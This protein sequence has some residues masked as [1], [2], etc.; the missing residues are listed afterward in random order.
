MCFC[1]GAEQLL[2]LL[3][4]RFGSGGSHLLMS[5]VLEVVLQDV[6]VFKSP[7]KQSVPVK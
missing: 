5:G 4:K 7:K 2:R 1:H 3:A 6:I